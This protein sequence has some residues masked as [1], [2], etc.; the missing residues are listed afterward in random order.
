M[1]M[2]DRR[3]LKPIQTQRG[4]IPFQN[5]HVRVFGHENGGILGSFENLS[6]C[7]FRQP[8]PNGQA[9]SISDKNRKYSTSSKISNRFLVKMVRL[10]RP[11]Q[12]SKSL[13]FRPTLHSFRLFKRV[14]ISLICECGPLA[15][16]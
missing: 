9:L 14:V 3:I 2:K 12:A 1:I 13:S 16:S 5:R 6:R 11:G 10:E 15:E 4:F 8:T 7:L